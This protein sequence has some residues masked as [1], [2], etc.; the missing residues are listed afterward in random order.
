MNL[1]GQIENMKEQSIQ[2]DRPTE[3]MKKKKQ[4]I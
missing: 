2:M 4:S 1:D 3:N